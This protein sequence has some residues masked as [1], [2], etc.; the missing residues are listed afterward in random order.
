M[1][2]LSLAS[3]AVWFLETGWFLKG[4][5]GSFFGFE[6]EKGARGFY[7]H[8]FSRW[9]PPPK[10]SQNGIITGYKIRW[11][12][13]GERKQETVTTDGSRRLFDIS[14]LLKGQ[15]YQVTLLDSI[16][17]NS[18]LFFAYFFKA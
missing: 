7:K 4:F 14:G 18:G 15:E 9:E 3:I 1:F 5:L 11:R 13:K 17:Y 2:P 10:E 8:S 16:R 12:Q 6:W